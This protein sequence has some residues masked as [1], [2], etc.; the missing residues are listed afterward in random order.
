MLPY[1]LLGLLAKQ[2][3]HGYDLKNAVEK[4]FGGQREI[5]FGQ[6]YTTLSRLERDGLISAGAT[7]DGRGKKIY[8]ITQTGRTELESWLDRIVE[9]AEP[10]K[11][12]FLVKLIIRHLAGYNDSLASITRQRQAYLQQL[13]D[14]GALAAQTS[15][16]PYV[17]LLIE[18]AMLHL[19]ADLRWLDICDERLERLE[20]FS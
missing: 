12:E 19:Q 15:D 5:N 11:D 10:Y 20:K 18:G 4:A 3:R 14:L 6:I 2:P 13:R 9:K 16:D 17:S 7:E 1:A 8:S